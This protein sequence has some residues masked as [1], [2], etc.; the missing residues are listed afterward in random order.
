M[1]KTLITLSLFTSLGALA[2]NG[3]IA[4]NNTGVNPNAN[5][6]LDIQ[7]EDKGILI[8]RLTTVARNT[9]GTALTVAL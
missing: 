6:M 5:A 3:G 8:P 4:I 1:K 9:L 7:S 2:Q